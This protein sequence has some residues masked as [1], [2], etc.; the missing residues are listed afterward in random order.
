MQILV[1]SNGVNVVRGDEC[2]HAQTSSESVFEIVLRQIEFELT[3]ELVD[4]IAAVARQLAR[5]AHTRARVEQGTAVRFNVL[6]RV[7]YI[8]ICVRR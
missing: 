3:I 7:L 4:A 6:R 5:V 2:P 8:G 1:Q